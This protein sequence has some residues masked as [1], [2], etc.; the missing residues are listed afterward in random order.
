MTFES[1]RGQIGGGIGGSFHHTVAAKFA[2]SNTLSLLKFTLFSLHTSIQIFKL[3]Y[4][5]STCDMIWVVS[6]LKIDFTSFYVKH[7]SCTFLHWISKSITEFQ[8]VFLR[9]YFVSGVE[10]KNKENVMRVY[11]LFSIK[12]F[13]ESGCFF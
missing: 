3:I 12:Q 8:R 2:S 1:R 6:I 7:I 13:D 4:D 9:F 11:M 10:I 5:A